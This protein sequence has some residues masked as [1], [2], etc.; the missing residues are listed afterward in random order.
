MN[1][2]SQRTTSDYR[3]LVMT[4]EQAFE[5]VLSIPER[6]RRFTLCDA[7]HGSAD[8]RAGSPHLGG[9]R[10]EGSAHPGSAGLRLGQVQGAEVEGFEGV[11]SHAPTPGRLF[12][13]MAGAHSLR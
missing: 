3:A 6:R 2:I 13:S 9:S 12:T 5:I 8:L 1:W 10:F 7:G 4:P 11:G